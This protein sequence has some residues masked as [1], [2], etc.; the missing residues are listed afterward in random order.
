MSWQSRAEKVL[1]PTTFSKQP[2]YY[3]RGVHPTHVR[4]G[5]GNYL[6]GPDN[7]V[8]FDTTGG[9]GSNLWEC[10]NNFA[11]PSTKEVILAEMLV[12]RI[13]CADMV[14]LVKTGSEAC[15]AAIRYARAFTDRGQTAGTGYHGWHNLFIAAESPG[16]GCYYE[17]YRKCQNLNEL[18]DY[19]D[20]NRDLAAVII[21]PWE[22]DPN[23]TDKLE[24]LR[25]VC[26]QNGIVLIFDEV[27]SG[28]RV[29]K[30][31]VANYTDVQPDLIVMGKAL[32]GGYPLGICAG[33]R[34]IMSTPGVFV[35][36]TFAGEEST[37]DAAIATMHKTTDDEL[38][39]FYDQANDFQRKF[40]YEGEGL[41]WLEGYGTRTV[42]RGQK[43]YAAILS[44]EMYRRYR[45][46]MM[47]NGPLIP[48]MSWKTS[49]YSLIITQMRP[50]VK[51]LDTL[52][53]EAEPEPIF[54]RVKD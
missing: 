45:T 5:Q 50:I 35:S 15:S 6:T 4:S 38:M 3:I 25:S 42:L 39:R 32:G 9:L 7:E 21:E 24:A 52:Q 54:K 48:H 23:V 31:V 16:A 17:G 8:I 27:I 22:L 18:T 41:V 44:Q 30:F 26:T 46:L 20:H 49:D 11:L 2:N 19:A 47:A 14:Q 29:P 13:R 53:L 37:L 34:D 51:E 1:K 36:S 12:T 10:R 28:A 33:R 43:N 40:N